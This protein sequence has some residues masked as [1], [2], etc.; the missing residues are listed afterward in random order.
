MGERDNTFSATQLAY[1][2][3]N[4]GT[5]ERTA[6]SQPKFGIDGIFVAADIIFLKDS[7]LIELIYY[8]D[9]K[10]SLKYN[11]CNSS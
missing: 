8:Q 4:G 1:N 11:T 5:N 2:T 10:I 3:I 9:A 7:F 6:T